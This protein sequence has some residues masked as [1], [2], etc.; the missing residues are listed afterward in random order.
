MAFNVPPDKTNPNTKYSLRQECTNRGP[1]NKLHIHI[2]IKII[3]DQ[4]V[5]SLPGW[6]RKI[7]DCT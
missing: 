3:K 2:E 4:T 7:G 5:R 6:T 1:V